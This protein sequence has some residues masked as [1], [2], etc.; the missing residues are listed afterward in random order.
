MQRPP[1]ATSNLQVSERVLAMRMA[2]SEASLASQSPLHCVPTI[3]EAAHDDQCVTTPDD[4]TT[5][6][7]D[8]DC[9]LEVDAFFA[10]AF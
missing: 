5:S 6:T 1:V 4:D 2:G 8:Y 3:T 9:K 7:T 10:C